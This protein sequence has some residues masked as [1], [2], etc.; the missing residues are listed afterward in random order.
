VALDRFIRFEGAAPS[1]RDIE[2]VLEIFF[3][4]LAE[5]IRWAVD[6]WFVF[7]VG[8][9]SKLAIGPSGEVIRQPA[10]PYRGGR[11]I[12][13]VAP[14]DRLVLDVITRQQD[15]ATNALAEGLA[16][17]CARYWEAEYEPP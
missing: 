12:E 6:R 10:E 9:E 2:Q 5:S 3:G 13:V 7:L 14:S 1:N 8:E 4:G 17:L 11:W 15:D 16:K